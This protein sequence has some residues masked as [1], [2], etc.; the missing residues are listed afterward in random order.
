MVRSTPAKATLGLTAGLMIVAALAWPHLAASRVLEDPSAKVRKLQQLDMVLTQDVLRVSQGLLRHYDTLDET[1]RAIERLSGEL[2]RSLE[3]VQK[4][5]EL[6][7]TIETYRVLH[8]ERA[9]QIE[10]FKSALARLRNSAQHFPRVVSAFFS[11]RLSEGHASDE[12]AVELKSL[13]TNVLVQQIAYDTRR[14]TELKRR[15]RALS[16]QAYSRRKL[17][18]PELL[19]VARHADIIVSERT[20]VEDLVTKLASRQ[21]ADM[22]RRWLIGH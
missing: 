19:V 21:G 16:A 15:I 13:L 20:R 11:E 18:D 1:N 22:L 12:L 9:D 3:N 7:R 8:A 10:R 2:A 14:S 4:A 5:A 17:I 6:R